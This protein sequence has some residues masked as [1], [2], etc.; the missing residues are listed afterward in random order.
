[1][2]RPRK[3]KAKDICAA[4]REL[5]REAARIKKQRELLERREAKAREKAGAKAAKLRERHAKEAAK[6]AE[7]HQ[8]EL[9]RLD[10]D[11]KCPPAKPRERSSKKSA[12]KATAKK[13]TEKGDAGAAGSRVPTLT[14]ALAERGITHRPGKGLSGLAL[15]DLDFQLATR[16]YAGTSHR[17]EARAREDQRAYVRAMEELRQQVLDRGGNLEDFEAF[18]R[19]WL[20]RSAELL[21]RRAGLMSSAIVG[22]ARFPAASQ[23]KKSD[24]YDRKAQEFREWAAK[25]RRA[26]LGED[27]SQA[28]I[29]STDDD[30]LDRLREKLAETQ[31]W[32]QLAKQAN[33]ILRRKKWS[34][35]QRLAAWRQLGVPE[36]EIARLRRSGAIILPNISSQI[37]RLEQRIAQLEELA[38]DKARGRFEPYERGPWRVTWDDEDGRVRVQGPKPKTRE[39][40]RA[41]SAKFKA[42]GFR[43]SPRSS[44]YQR[45]ATENAWHAARSIV[46][47]LATVA[48]SAAA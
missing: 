7:R 28:A 32:R 41:Q 20:R 10:T 21:N 38:E 14:E 3:R 29:R 18:R 44:A 42:R 35:E 47:E 23:R 24:L 2:A 48:P 37:R 8:R 39:A 25:R 34:D 31:R 4:R 19:E 11:V 17:P 26:L 1:M 22:P 43:W 6:L 27:R 36:P 30:A 15:D 40:T 13:A 12:K 9:S 45:Q 16:A 5:D 46:D 33:V